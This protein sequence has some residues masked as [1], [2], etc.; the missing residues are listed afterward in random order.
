MYKIL[1]SILYLQ[2][3]TAP[4]ATGDVPITNPIP[5]PPTT[6][7]AS[8]EE[9]PSSASPSVNPHSSI[10]S[11]PSKTPALSSR[12]KRVKVVPYLR[13]LANELRQKNFLPEKQSS[14]ILRKI[15]TLEQQWSGDSTDADP[16]LNAEAEEK[17][18]KMVEAAED[19][20]WE[21]ALKIQVQ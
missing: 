11:S 21:Q 6:A 5:T 2:F 19:G 12:E 3:L 7:S 13:T 10:S 17:L 16:P 15:L 20:K 9:T 8:S 1:G 4:F 14:D 18:L